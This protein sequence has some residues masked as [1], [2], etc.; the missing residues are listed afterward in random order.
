MRIANGMFAVLRLCQKM[1]VVML[2][3]MK[4]ANRAV[5]AKV[6]ELNL[7]CETQWKDG[8]KTQKVWRYRSCIHLLFYCCSS[9]QPCAAICTAPESKRPPASLPVALLQH[10]HGI[11]KKKPLCNPETTRWPFALSNAIWKPALMIENE[12]AE[13]LPRLLGRGRVLG[14]SLGTLGDGVLGELAGEDQAHGGLD[15]AG[16]DGGLLVVGC[17][18]GGLGCDALE[19][20]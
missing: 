14:D 5:E 3:V 15:L 2:Q 16:G 4:V 12:N 10:S 18:L 13:V 20:V 1:M 7:Q 9:S 17:E 19:D 8:N 11:K 6:N